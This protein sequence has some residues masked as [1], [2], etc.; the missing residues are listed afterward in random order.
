MSII[1]DKL[2]IIAIINLNII[3]SFDII[4]ILIVQKID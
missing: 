3:F 1:N 2:K 4:K